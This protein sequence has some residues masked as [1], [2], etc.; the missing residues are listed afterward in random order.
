MIELT[1]L[2]R[3]LRRVGCTWIGSLGQAVPSARL[4]AGG[5]RCSGRDPDDRTLSVLLSWAVG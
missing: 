2:G 1:H 5:L 4:Y 3:L